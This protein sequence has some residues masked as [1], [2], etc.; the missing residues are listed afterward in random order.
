MYS[1]IRCAIGL[2]FESH[3]PNRTE[4]MLKTRDDVLPPIPV[5]HQAELGILRLMGTLVAGI[6]NDEAA[7]SSEHRLRV[8]GKALIGV[9]PRAQA[10]GIGV[11]LGEHRVELAQTS[12][13]RTVGHVGTGVAGGL[14]LAGAQDTLDE[15]CQLVVV[16]CGARGWVR[17]DQRWMRD[18]NSLLL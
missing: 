5:R 8:A 7:R 15:G 11:E 2:V 6:G 16:D 12:D 10:V 17:A 13:R 14:E 1:A 3:F 4:L 9:V 18:W